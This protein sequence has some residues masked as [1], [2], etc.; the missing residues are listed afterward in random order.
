MSI[1]FRT[2]DD[3]PPGEYQVRVRVGGRACRR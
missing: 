3:L 2:A 1:P